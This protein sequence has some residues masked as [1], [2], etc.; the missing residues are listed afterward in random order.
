M[1]VIA[2]GQIAR[3]LAVLVDALPG[4]HG[5]TPVRE[6][7]EMLG[8]KGANQAVAMAQ[9]GLRPGM[10]GV[11]GDDAVADR[12]L[13]QLACDGV[14]GTWVTRRPG[15][16][17]GLVVDVV[18]CG[19]SW[20]YLE[21]LPPEVLLGEADLTAA[22]D[23]LADVQ[24]V[25]IQLQQPAPVALTAARMARRGATTVV[26]DGAPQ[27]P[28]LRPALL[29]EADVLRADHREA[30]LLAGRPL[31]GADDTVRAARELLECGPGLVV[32][33]AGQEGNV[34]VWD[35]GEV[36]VPLADVVV[37]DTT[38]GGDAFVAG[39]VAGLA[40][41]AGPEQ[42]G[43]LATAAA[44]STVRRLGGRPHLTP[45]G[46]V[47]QLARMQGRAWHT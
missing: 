22:A 9:L 29:A 44:A 32:L 25:V 37:V 23:A 33:D 4:P 10:V 17:T 20:R 24:T 7:R 28:R 40:C 18:D 36:V 6:R 14:A 42:A 1:D 38:G 5:T 2:L 35:G 15:A 8:G 45:V 39:L 12:L 30:E 47:E 19:R 3:D 16:A 21:D 26:L 34:L 41:G 11:V 13:E 27:D 46:V 31:R 43:R